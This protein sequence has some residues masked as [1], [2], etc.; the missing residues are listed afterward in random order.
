MFF[1]ILKIVKVKAFN[2]VVVK[3]LTAAFGMSGSGVSVP[4]RMILY[5]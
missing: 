4:Y 3:A 5:D 2:T 1:A